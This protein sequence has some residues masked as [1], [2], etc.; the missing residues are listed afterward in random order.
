[1][2]GISCWNI[3]DPGGGHAIYDGI[4]LVV[5]LPMMTR[6]LLRMISGPVSLMVSPSIKVEKRMVSPEAAVDTAVL[7]EIVPI[8]LWVLSTVMLLAYPKWEVHKKTMAKRTRRVSCM[9]SDL[10]LPNSI[11]R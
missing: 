2:D 6:F 5:L 7:N 10:G 8:V 11:F 3:E 9:G 1:M 4:V